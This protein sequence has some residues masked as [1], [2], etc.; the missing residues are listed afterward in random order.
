MKIEVLGPGCPKCERLA[1]N[2]QSAVEKT[3]AAADVV[4]VTDIN[5]ITSRG[6][7]MTPAL[8]ID[9]AVKTSG[10]VPSADDIANMLS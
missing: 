9:G 8:V 4:K 7:M 10:S 3:G 1:A 6:V 5:E 2:V